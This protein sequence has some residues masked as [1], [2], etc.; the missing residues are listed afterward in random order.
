M[1]NNRDLV[2]KNKKH[3]GSQADKS[4]KDSAATKESKT[5][6][7]SPVDII[8]QIAR[9]I[10]VPPVLVSALLVL[11]FFL[12]DTVFVSV[13]QL[14]LALVFLVAIPLAAYPL[15]YAVPALRKKGRKAQRNLAFALS[16]TGYGAAVVYGLVAQVESPLLLIFLT[17]FLSVIGLLFF[18]LVL[19]KHAS[20]HAC[21]TM[22]PLVFLVYFIG[23]YGLPIC[24]LVA[25]LV[26]WSSL[27]TKSHTVSE[28]IFGAA[29]AVA[30]F[31]VAL[32]LMALAAL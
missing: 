30:A 20:G 10:T 8:A 14:V 23:P 16:L 9:V 31:L 6:K 24:A 11:L 13:S 28:L 2:L 15:S 17:Y 5:L 3:K 21:S 25:A 7:K 29:T 18:N 26:V 32:G 19:K 1:T 27:H 22:G 4:R 12:N